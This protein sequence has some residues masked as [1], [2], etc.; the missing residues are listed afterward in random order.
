MTARFLIRFFFILGLTLMPFLSAAEDSTMDPLPESA[1]TEMPGE[2][3][4]GDPILERFTFLDLEPIDE[5]FQVAIANIPIPP[6]PAAEPGP[7]PAEEEPLELIADPLEPVNRAFFQFNDRLY[8]W[9]LKPVAKGYAAVVPQDLRVGVRN[10]FNNLAAPIRVTNCLLQ[11]N[12]K[13]AGTETARFLL[14]TTMG[15][16]GFLDPAKT[17]FHLQRNEE[18]LGQTLGVYGLGPVLYL[19]W[20][21]LGP[22]S[23]RD[24]LGYVGDLFLDPQN[25]LVSSYLVKLGVRPVYII[26]ETSLNLGDY[27]DLKASAIDPYTALKDIYQQYRENKI[28]ER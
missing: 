23:L 25:Y 6:E 5:P 3:L 28:R 15:L 22:S 2:G 7:E 9:V 20:P 27:E 14:N 8:F 17:E 19:N 13:G 10:F 18:D 12:F 21:I 4:D 11:A 26:N 16:A 24:T 1:S